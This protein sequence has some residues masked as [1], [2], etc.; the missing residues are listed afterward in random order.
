MRDAGHGIVDRWSAGVCYS[1]GASGIRSE[2]GPVH[3]DGPKSRVQSGVRRS[4]SKQSIL[5]NIRNTKRGDFSWFTVSSARR[6]DREQPRN[7][8]VGFMYYVRS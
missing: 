7:T 2:G 3:S 1:F 6:V 8:P 5:W 4:N